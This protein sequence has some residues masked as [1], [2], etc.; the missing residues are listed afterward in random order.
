MHF[1]YPKV[2]AEIMLVGEPGGPNEQG[3]YWTFLGGFPSRGANDMYDEAKLAKKMPCVA[4][5]ANAVQ[6]AVS[7]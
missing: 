6:P 7:H 3:S 5:W 2:P 1:W 4:K